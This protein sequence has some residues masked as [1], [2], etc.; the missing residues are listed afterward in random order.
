M[1]LHVY[2]CGD[3][4]QRSELLIHPSETSPVSCPACG[5]TRMQ[6]EFATFAVGNSSP[7]SKAAEGACP[8]PGGCP[9]GVCPM[10]N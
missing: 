7:S 4:H 2:T 9:G 1:P 3:C 5:S 6:R 10:M 8:M